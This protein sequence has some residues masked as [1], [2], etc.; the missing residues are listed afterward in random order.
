MI[1]RFLIAKTIFD[2]Y[3]LV[4]APALFLPW[5]I[6]LLSSLARRGIFGYL[7]LL[8]AVLFAVLGVTLLLTLTLPDSVT[9]LA[10]VLATW[11]FAAAITVLCRNTKQHT[12]PSQ[13][14]CATKLSI[15]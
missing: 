11:L 8:L 15:N 6:V 14:H 3:W 10:V 5:G 13:K 2:G 9:V 12:S 7:V 1:I 4:F